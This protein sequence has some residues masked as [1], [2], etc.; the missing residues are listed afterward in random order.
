ML[1]ILL[2]HLFNNELKE[3]TAN[4]IFNT[5]CIQNS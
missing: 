3:K 2:S 1:E 4:L 5:L